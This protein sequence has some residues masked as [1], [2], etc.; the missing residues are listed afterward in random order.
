VVLLVVETV[1]QFGYSSMFVTAFPLSC[2]MAL[3]NN[4]VEIR[5]DAWK[6]LE[7]HRRPLPRSCED[8]G[9]WF[10]MLEVISDGVNVC[11]YV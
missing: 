4:Y 8:M 1:I 6:M 9:T 10:P 5:L 3:V 7:L 2:L 11:M